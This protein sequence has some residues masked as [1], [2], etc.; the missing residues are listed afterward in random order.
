M[1]REDAMII[2]HELTALEATIRNMKA[3]L[4]RIE[5]QSSELHNILY[6]VIAEDTVNR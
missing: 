2:K 5:A 4:H 3:Y 6:K 1:S